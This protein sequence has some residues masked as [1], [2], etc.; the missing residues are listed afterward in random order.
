MVCISSCLH[1]DDL[2]KT[3]DHVRSIPAISIFIAP[4]V[5]SAGNC[6]EETE[7]RR[8]LT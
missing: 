6:R 7:I 4:I 2:V 1:V 3:I 5:C 8:Y